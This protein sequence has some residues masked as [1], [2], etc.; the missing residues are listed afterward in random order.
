MTG[1]PN[2]TT[3]DVCLTVECIKKLCRILPLPK[4]LG[5]A[6]YLPLPG[7][8]MFDDCQQYGYKAPKTIEEWAEIDSGY[9]FSAY[10]RPWIKDPDIV[11]ILWFYS[12]LIGISV[13]K[14]I[15]VIKRYSELVGYSKMKEIILIVLAVLGS[16]LGRT[17]YGLK[18]FKFPIETVIFKKFRALNA[19]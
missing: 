9:G 12:I 11:R 18:F 6:L 19:Q 3:E 8:R 5:P 15:R 13:K 7:S 2:E 1:L 10:E 14:I 16:I 4:I 17:R